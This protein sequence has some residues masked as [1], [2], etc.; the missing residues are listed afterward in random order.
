MARDLGFLGIRAMA[1]A[2]GAME[3]PIIDKYFEKLGVP[4]EAVP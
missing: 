1:I 3:T 4:S 2:P